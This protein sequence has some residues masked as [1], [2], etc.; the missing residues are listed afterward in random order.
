MACSSTSGRKANGVDCSSEGVGAYYDDWTDRYVEAFGETIQAHRPSREGE[1]LNY[2]MNRA[3]LRNGFRV[4]DAGCGICGPARY[5]AARRQIEIEALTI[6][7]VQAE[8]ARTRNKAAKLDRSINV[9]LGDFHRLI[10]IYGREQFDV[11]YFL[12]SLSHSPHP[13]AVVQSAYEVLRP[14]GFLYI[15]DF[16]I[17][18]CDTPEEQ[19]CVLDVVSRVDRIFCVRTAWARDMLAWLRAENFIPLFV[20]TPQFDVDNTLWQSFEDKYQFDLFAGGKPFD[21]S[22]WLEM[23]FQKP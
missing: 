15:K 7:P 5:F 18:R 23:K 11:V 22:E 3:G 17:R 1:F 20:E 13:A 21:W 10:D 16:F 9:W 19:E 12:E 14:G 8:I 4:L 2:L 6:S